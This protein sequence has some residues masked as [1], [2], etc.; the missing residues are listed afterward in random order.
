MKKNFFF[1][2]ILLEKVIHII[3][4][5]IFFFFR[6]FR[7]ANFINVYAKRVQAFEVEKLTNNEEL[8]NS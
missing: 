3:Y 6:F 1:S 2:V 7:S 4:R 5:F 8:Q